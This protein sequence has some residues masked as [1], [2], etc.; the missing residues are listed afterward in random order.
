M[1]SMFSRLC[2][3]SCAHTA[4]E[5]VVEEETVVTGLA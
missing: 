2:T 5:V 3:N 1:F 4:E